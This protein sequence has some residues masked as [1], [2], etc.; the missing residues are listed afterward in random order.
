MALNA[1]EHSRP[2]DPEGAAAWQ[3][4]EEDI[5]FCRLYGAWEPC[6]PAELVLLME[7]FPA[8]WWLVGGHAIEAFTG[9][10]RHHEDVDMVI[11][12]RDVQHLRDQLG[13]RFHLWSNAGGTFRVIN[14]RH[15][16]PLDPLSQIWVREHAQA[17][18]RIDIILNPDAE[19]QWQSKRD[20]EHVADLASVT[21]VHSDGIRYLNP[22]IVLL[23]KAADHRTKDEIDLANAWPLLDRQQR[24]WL[25]ESVRRLYPEHPWRDRLA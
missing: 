7:G 19:G 14:D 23:F 24:D 25:R 17:P 11:Y 18:W 12:C 2:G 3:P 15:P 16:E 9:V 22:E 1:T 8:P 10:Q 20:D 21:W 6:S 4:D 13:D 5:A